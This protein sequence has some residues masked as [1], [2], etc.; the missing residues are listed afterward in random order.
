VLL[1]A[2]SAMHAVQATA[3]SMGDVSTERS[4]WRWFTGMG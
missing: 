3:T 2:V 1:Q 4:L